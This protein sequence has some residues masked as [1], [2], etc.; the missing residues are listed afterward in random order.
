M[1]LQEKL[2]V[3]FLCVENAGRSQMAAALAEREA[4]ERGIDTVVEVHSAGTSPAEEIHE[5]VIEAMAEIDIDI[6]DRSPKWVVVED[7]EQSH[8]VV[9]MGCI[10][11]EFS[12]S[13]YGVEYRAWNLKDPKGEDIKT[14]RAIRDDLQ[15]RVA[16]LF[17]EIEDTA[18][19]LETQ[20][21]FSQRVTNTIKDVL[22]F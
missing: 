11:N 16:N 12:P 7:L 5:P 15:Q 14:V 18:N 4:T 21:S 6:S 2:R 19:D 17:D 9:T 13:A 3:D 20:P 22:S 10:I 8:F 1:A